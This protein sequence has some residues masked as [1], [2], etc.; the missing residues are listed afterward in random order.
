M[1]YLALLFLLSSTC[2]HAPLP[3]KKSMNIGLDRNFLVSLNDVDQTLQ[4]LFAEYPATYDATA[5]H[6]PAI[7]IQ[8]HSPTIIDLKG[9]E[10][11]YD[12][13]YNPKTHILKIKH[14]TKR[15]DCIAQGSLIHEMFHFILHME[16]GDLDKTH[17]TKHVWDEKDGIMEKIKKKAIQKVCPRTN[18]SRT[19]KQ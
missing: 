8:K 2:T 6:R 16:T 1:R 9:V 19:T 3:K 18:T 7:T 17:K 10:R 14:P 13:T 4:I 11:G 15:G 5:K 12:G